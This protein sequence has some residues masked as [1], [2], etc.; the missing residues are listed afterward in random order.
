MGPSCGF[1]HDD[2]V[3]HQ[4]IQPIKSLFK[5]LGVGIRPKRVAGTDQHGPKAIRAVGQ[6]FLGHD[7]GG[8]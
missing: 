2:V 8:E 1:A 6:D 4:K 7:I 5:C 3:D